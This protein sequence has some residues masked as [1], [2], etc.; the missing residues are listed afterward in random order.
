MECQTAME[1]V[2]I[3]NVLLSFLSLPPTAHIASLRVPESE[4]LELLHLQ[5]SPC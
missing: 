2:A 5:L 1:L 3:T 4:D